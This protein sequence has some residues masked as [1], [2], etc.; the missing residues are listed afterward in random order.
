MIHTESIVD[1]YERLFKHLKIWD[2]CNLSDNP[3]E[4]W[5]SIDNEERESIVHKEQNFFFGQL[6]SFG[7]YHGVTLNVGSD[8]YSVLFF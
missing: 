7:K 6:G 2:A 8:T 3:S 1:E 4:M 5:K